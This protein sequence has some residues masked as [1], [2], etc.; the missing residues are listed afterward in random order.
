M[1]EDK[2]SANSEPA[3][4]N[5]TPPIQPSGQD[6]E[7]TIETETENP[8]QAEPAL[9][10]DSADEIAPEQTAGLKDKSFSSTT[11]KRIIIIGAIVVAIAISGFLLYTYSLKP[12]GLYN[13]ASE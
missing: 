10:L 3:P 2:T 9:E 12:L 6:A 8:P 5:E 11:K 13:T 4:Q 7:A 1:S